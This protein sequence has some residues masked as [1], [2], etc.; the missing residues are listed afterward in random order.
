MVL[1]NHQHTLQMGKVEVPETSEKFHILMLPSARENFI[2]F[3]HRE[4][5]KTYNTPSRL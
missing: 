2:E 4:S 3:S 1:P 5:F